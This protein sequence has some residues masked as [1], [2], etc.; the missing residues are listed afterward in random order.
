MLI[1]IV[2]WGSMSPVC[3]DWSAPQAITMSLGNKDYVTRLHHHVT[4]EKDGIPMR[5]FRHL[6]KVF[7]VGDSCSLWRVLQAFVLCRLFTCS[8]TFTK[9]KGEIRKSIIGPLRISIENHLL[10]LS[11]FKLKKKV[12]QLFEIVLCIAVWSHCRR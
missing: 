5:R 1:V 4:E 12:R 10:C 3:S 2:F 11:H 9:R 6:R 8:R 7:F